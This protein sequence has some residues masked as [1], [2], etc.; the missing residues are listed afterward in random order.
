M[1]YRNRV[2]LALIQMNEGGTADAVHGHL[3]KMGMASGF[4][5]TFS[6]L[7][8]L[9]TEGVIDCLKEEGNKIFRLKSRERV[10]IM[11]LISGYVEDNPQGEVAGRA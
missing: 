7:L 4:S 3:N 11:E 5:T 1:P 8:D 10:H 2:L 6:H 9:A